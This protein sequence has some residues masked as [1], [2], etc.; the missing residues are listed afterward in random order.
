MF[1]RT[2]TASIL[3]AALLVI[4]VSAMALSD[5]SV[6]ELLKPGAG[7]SGQ[8]VITF[9]VINPS[10][11]SLKPDGQIVGFVVESDPPDDIFTP[12]AGWK[13]ATIWESRWY[14]G[15][16]VLGANLT[17]S[18]FFGG[19]NYPLSTSYGTGYFLD[20]TPDDLGA[21]VLTF[22][23][24]LDNAA[25]SPGETLTGFNIEVGLGPM[26]NY[27]LAHV[28]NAGPPFGDG[29]VSGF[30]TFRGETQ[31]IPEPSTAVLLG[32]GLVGA[33]AAARRYKRP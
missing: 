6:T 28:N 22:S 25:I 27:V 10:D 13:G 3:L 32:F 11:S 1:D 23:F 5:P 7:S 24:L 12:N 30:S 15:M 19:I 26:T 4:P 33:L 16:P 9:T 20:Y 21:S 29:N 14:Q 17:W 31:V 18:N 8:D 2:T